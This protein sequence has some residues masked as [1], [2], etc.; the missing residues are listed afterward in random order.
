M[1]H[2]ANLPIIGEFAD[3]ALLVGLAVD[4]EEAGWDGVFVWDTLLFDTQTM[5]P[6]LDPWTVLAV[7]AIRTRRVRVGPMMAQL[8]RRPPWDV[9]RQVVTVDRLSEGRLIL[10][11]ALGYAAEADF[12]HFGLASDART[13]AE[14][15]DE[16]LEIIAGLC[17]G[18][19]FQHAG[20]HFTID[21]SVFRPGPIQDPVP[22]WIGGYW[23]NKGPMRRAARWHGAFPAP[24]VVPT[25]KCFAAIPLAPADVRTVRR[26]IEEHRSTDEPFDLVIS[27]P[28]PLDDPPA[29][30]AEVES[31][32]Q[33]GVT[34]IV[35]DWLPW[36]TGPDEVR[37]QIRSGPLGS[38]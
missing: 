30:A 34:W 8:A 16:S 15:L 18:V 35:R 6:V 3:P 24:Q 1:F 23:P 28:L 27:H 22:V 20:R 2:G 29:A 32:E 13:R 37:A 17:S 25:Q 36:E 9:A 19:P 12:A 33:V 26:Y 11:A 31:Y 14:Q 21:N 4:A 7:I 10:G 38:N 5:P